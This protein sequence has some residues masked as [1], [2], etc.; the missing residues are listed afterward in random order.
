MYYNLYASEVHMR[1]QISK[2]KN[3]ISFYIVESIY[4]DGIRSNK[5]VENSEL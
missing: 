3:A 5:V 2:S 4:V 1:L